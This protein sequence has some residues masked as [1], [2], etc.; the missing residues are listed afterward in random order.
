[1]W[2]FLCRLFGHRPEVIFDTGS[3][4][5]LTCSR[6]HENT[7][8]PSTTSLANAVHEPDPDWLGGGST[9]SPVVTE[10]KTEVLHG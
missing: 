6:C 1:M 2:A 9:T 10:T 5:Y 4:V 7:L 8:T 3:W